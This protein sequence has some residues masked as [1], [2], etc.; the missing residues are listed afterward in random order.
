LL[1][2]YLILNL[3]PE[4]RKWHF[5]APDSKVFWGSMAPDP[6]RGRGPTSPE[7]LQPPTSELIET[8]EFFHSL[9]SIVHSALCLPPKFCI[10][11]CFELSLEVCI[12]PRAFRNSGLCR[13]WGAGRVHYGELENREFASLQLN[14]S[15]RVQLTHE[16]E[17]QVSSITSS[18][19]I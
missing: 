11:C 9:F 15:A 2:Q 7:V 19:V 17:I 12:F 14:S 10:N 3:I 16:G 1:N 13:V 8:L 5:W 6:P 4:C 18:A